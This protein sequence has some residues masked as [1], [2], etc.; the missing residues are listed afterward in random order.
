MH[1]NLQLLI[2]FEIMVR[3]YFIFMTFKWTTTKFFKNIACLFL[4][5]K[6]NRIRTRYVVLR[7]R[8]IDFEDETNWFP[9]QALSYLGKPEKRECPSANLESCD[10][11]LDS[12]WPNILGHVSKMWWYTHMGWRYFGNSQITL[13]YRSFYSGRRWLIMKRDIYMNTQGINYAIL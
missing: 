1:C 2:S 7:M 11:S 8:N 6:T 4:Q 12:T 10:V 13:T 9:S 3:F 5:E